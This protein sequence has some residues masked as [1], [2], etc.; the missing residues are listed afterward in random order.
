MCKKP[1]KYVSDLGNLKQLCRRNVIKGC[2]LLLTRRGSTKAYEKIVEE[3]L[4]YL[5]HWHI[6]N[7]LTHWHT[8]GTLEAYTV[9]SKH[10]ID[11]LDTNRKVSQPFPLNRYTSVVRDT[12]VA[13]SWLERHKKLRITEICLYFFFGTI[14]ERGSRTDISQGNMI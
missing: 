3:T 12:L 11:Y 14:H 9:C 10:T 6:N 1:E 8:Q 4:K 13:G 7:T 2:R 5:T